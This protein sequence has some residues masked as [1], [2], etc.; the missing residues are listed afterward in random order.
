MKKKKKRGQNNRICAALKQN[1]RNARRRPR[2]ELSGKRRGDVPWTNGMAERAIGR[3]K[4]RYKTVRGYKSELRLLN[5]FGLTQRAWIGS[6]SL[7]LL[8]LV[9]A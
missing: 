9:A 4:I 5:G 7:D 6:G 2:V 8:G 1:S 3:S